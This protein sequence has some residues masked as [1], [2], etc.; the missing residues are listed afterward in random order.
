VPN[1]PVRR[2][3]I[4]F[5]GRRPFAAVE[6]FYR[7]SEQRIGRFFQYEDEDYVFVVAQ[8]QCD[9][10]WL[11]ALSPDD[12]QTLDKKE[13]LSLL[14]KRHYHWECGCTEERMMRVLLPSMK[15]SP[16]E[17]FGDEPLVR[18]SCPRCGLRYVIT[19][20]AMEGFQME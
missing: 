10:E 6:S 1:Q 2:S 4:N 18:M 17:L 12:I 15:A 5:E 11:E 16:E 13:T 3:A 7:Q 9:L 19:R 20:E 8:P 14:E